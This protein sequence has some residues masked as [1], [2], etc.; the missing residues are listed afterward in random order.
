MKKAVTCYVSRASEKGEMAHCLEQLGAGWL[1]TRPLRTEV[2]VAWHSLIRSVC[3]YLVCPLLDGTLD[4]MACI[5]FP[6]PGPGLRACSAPL[7]PAPI[8]PMPSKVGVDRFPSF[9]SQGN[10][11]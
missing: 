10:E 3:S 1:V 2:K 6:S 9:A 4:L 11:V 7:L 8:L 5:N